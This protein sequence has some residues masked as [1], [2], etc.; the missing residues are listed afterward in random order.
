[1]ILNIS[2]VTNNKNKIWERITHL[3]QTII[4]KSIFA[5]SQFS[6]FI[7]KFKLFR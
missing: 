4:D 1:M 7:S 5:M 2:I 6:Q 3:S